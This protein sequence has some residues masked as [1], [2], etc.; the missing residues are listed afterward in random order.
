MATW[1]VAL[2]ATSLVMASACAPAPGPDRARDA[3][4]L[5]GITVRVGDKPLAVAAGDLDGDGLLDLVS[6]DAG[7]RQISIRLQRS[8]GGFAAAPAVAAG[9]EPHLVAVGHLDRDGGLDLVATGHDD[10]AVHAWLGDGKGR[11]RSAPGSP[12]PAL[13]P[14]G[15]PHNHGL[16]VGDV[17]GD[18]VSDVVTADQSDRS[19]SVLLGDGRGSLAPAPGSPVALGGEPYPPELADLSR[20][21]RLDIV[22][23]LV[24]A[25]GVAVLLGDGK[26]GFAAAPGSPFATEPRP[27]ALAVADLDRDGAA[28]VVAAHDDT[29]HVSV[30]LGDGRGRLRH[31]PGSPVAVGT[32]VWRMAVADVDGDGA[33]DIAAG[34][35]RGVVLLLGDG[36]GRLRVRAERLVGPA[37]GWSAMAAD[38]DGD[39]GPDLVAPDA[40]G[41]A[42]HVW[43]SRGARSGR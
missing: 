12:F 36:R 26:G 35:D 39:G 23:P 22:V 18:R 33:A 19:V 24:G 14:A 32:R 2:S 37:Q 3:L 34:F 11:F 20:D 17:D 7:A 10:A 21:G 40:L 15:R 41:A 31:A 8:G 9:F 28:D 43:R 1:I 27:Y 4:H 30:L 13:E 6:A 42:L 16:A 38:L 25:A 5:P 29:D